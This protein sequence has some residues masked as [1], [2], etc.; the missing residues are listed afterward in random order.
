M[1]DIIDAAKS[2]D[3]KLMKQLLEVG[4]DPNFTE[5]TE[6]ITPLH[7]AILHHSLEVI[8]LLIESG[9]NIYAQSVCGEPPIDLA[10]E[11][12]ADQVISL[13]MQK[14]FISL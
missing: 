3:S 14:S 12:G 11:I 7:F 9:A 5:D 4:I 8:P 13:L 2:N 6:G 1:N 10:L